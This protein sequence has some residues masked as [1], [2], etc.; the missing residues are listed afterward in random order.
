MFWKGGT[1]MPDYEKMYKLLFNRITDALTEL[2]KYNVG[3]AKEILIK[4]HQDAEEIYI[5]DEKPE[6]E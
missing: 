4:A 6:D 3:T 2:D 1:F 5:N